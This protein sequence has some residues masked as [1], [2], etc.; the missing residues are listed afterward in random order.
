MTAHTATQD[1]RPPAGAFGRL[2]ALQVRMTW[3]EPWLPL[4][5]LVLPFGFLIAFSTVPS[6]AKPYPPDPRLTVSAY[7]MPMWIALALSFIALFALPQP[8]VRDRENHWLRRISTTPAPPSWLLGAHTLINAVLALVAVAVLT[9]GSVAFFGM[10]VGQ[11]AG[12]ALAALLFVT[13]M[14]ALGLLVTAVARTAGVAAGLANALFFP[15]MFFGGLWIQR[16][17]M[18]PT[19][20]AIS[21]YTPLMAASQALRD[22]MLGSFPSVSNLLV[23]AGWTV[24]CGL[25]AVRFFR[26]E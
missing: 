6:F 7:L 3:R 18:A 10:V 5:G 20:Q 23:L 22:A 14:F 1:Y 13:A 15:L 19:L 12:Y 4:L 11:P 9:L 21:D 26:W 17:D 16:P 25:A 8:F 2:V 24:V